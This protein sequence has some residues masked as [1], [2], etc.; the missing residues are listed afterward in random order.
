MF[1]SDHLMHETEPGVSHLVWA[2]PSYRVGWLVYVCAAYCELAGTALTLLDPV[3]GREVG[4]YLSNEGHAVERDKS[5]L[6]ARDGA[7]DG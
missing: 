6:A 7:Y 2:L 4:Q 3:R 1:G 5:M